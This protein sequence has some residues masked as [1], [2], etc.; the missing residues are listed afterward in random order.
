MA[1][2]ERK[3]RSFPP[4]TESRRLVRVGEG[5]GCSTFRAADESRKGKPFT[6]VQEVCCIQAI[7]VA[8]REINS[9]PCFGD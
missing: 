2:A 6:A 8:T 7:W 4:S 1:K 9:R 3:T 5:A